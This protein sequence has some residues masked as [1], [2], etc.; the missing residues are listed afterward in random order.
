MPILISRM[1]AKP[2]VIERVAELRRAAFFHESAYTLAEDREA[3][4]RIAASKG[5]E[6]Q[7]F[8]ADAEGT[9]VGSG[10]LV[11]REL[12]QYHDFGPWLAGLVVHPE[13]RGQGIGSMLVRAIEDQARR[14]EAARL[15]LYTY[16]TERFYRGLDWSLSERF[17]DKVGA[18]CALMV[19][20]LGDLLPRGDDE[21]DLD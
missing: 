2:S 7:G 15:Y 10:L 9:I 3:L 14:N 17:T 6:E 19:R 13:W 1:K 18:Q 21:D 5:E 8:V 12:D 20:D 16:E 11:R 4:W